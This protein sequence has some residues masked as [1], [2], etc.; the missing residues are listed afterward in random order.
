MRTRFAARPHL[1][2]GGA[3]FVA[4]IAVAA[5]S[6][7]AGCSDAVAPASGINPALLDASN[8][9]GFAGSLTDGLPQGAGTFTGPGGIPMDATGFDFSQQLTLLDGTVL[10]SSGVGVTAVPDESVVGAPIDYVSFGA[11]NT[12]SF[13]AV[14]VGAY[15]V[16]W[17]TFDFIHEVSFGYALARPPGQKVADHADAGTVTITSLQYFSDEIPCTRKLTGIVID[18]CTYRIGVVAG[19]V[20]YRMT[21]GDGT[22]IVQNRASFSLPVQR[23]VLVAHQVE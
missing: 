17:P 21:L 2:S 7:L 15:D 20:E 18:R 9:A 11:V 22:E 16:A 8:G 10:R 13:D 5:L 14:Q 12:G 1:R 6:S 3:I 4:A 23:Q 19:T